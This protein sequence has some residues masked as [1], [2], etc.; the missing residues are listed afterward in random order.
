LTSLPSR[1]WTEPLTPE[2]RRRSLNDDSTPDVKL[3]NGYVRST[4]SQVA[5]A[6]A[7]VIAR[8]SAR[9]E[10]DAD[11]VQH[12]HPVVKSALPAVVTEEAI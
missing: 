1:A 4:S 6:T 9:G 8:W 12:P 7:A 3:T 5:W 11:D 2:M 10:G